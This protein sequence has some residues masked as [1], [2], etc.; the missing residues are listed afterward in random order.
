MRAARL[1]RK[2]AFDSSVALSLTQ[3]RSSDLVSGGGGRYQLTPESKFVV[4]FQTHSLR[5]L[6]FELDRLF[7]DLT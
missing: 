6:Y 3:S 4:K 5:D 2:L 1:I 7:K